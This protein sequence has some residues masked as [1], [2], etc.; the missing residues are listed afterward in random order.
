MRLID[1][2]AL[3]ESEVKRCKDTDIFVCVI[4]TMQYAWEDM[5]LKEVL[6]AR[7]TIEED[8][9]IK[10]GHWIISSDGYYLY[11]SECNEEPQGREMTK[12]CPNCG[13]KMDRDNKD[14]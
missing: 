10:R 8:S 9:L 2:D 4:D 12:W 3:W 6:D 5:P 7:S 13:A 1:A 14:D 11:C